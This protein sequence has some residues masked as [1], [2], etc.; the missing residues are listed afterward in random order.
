MFSIKIKESIEPLFLQRKDDRFLLF[1][2]AF[3]RE[4]DLCITLG[5]GKFVF[6]LKVDWV[7]MKYGEQW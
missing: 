6:Q 4:T 5:K 1:S 3:T 7:G 2:K